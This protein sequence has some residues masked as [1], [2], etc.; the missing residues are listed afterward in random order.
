MATP[1]HTPMKLNTLAEALPKCKT[2]SKEFGRRGNGRMAR[3]GY[4]IPKLSPG[5][6]MPGRIAYG[7]VLPLWTPHTVRLCLPTK[8]HD[9][10]V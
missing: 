5:P 8:T 10:I 2:G 7:R 6:I 4:G 9:L 3:S 1:S